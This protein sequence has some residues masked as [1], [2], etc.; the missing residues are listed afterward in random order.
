[1]SSDPNIFECLLDPSEIFDFYQKIGITLKN[2]RDIANER[3]RGH[4]LRNTLML[5]ERTEMIQ[6]RDDEYSKLTSC[7]TFDS[8]YATLISGIKN[9]YTDEVSTIINCDKHYDEVKNQF[10]IY[11]NDIPLR[12]MGLAMLME[13]TREFLRVKNRVYFIGIDNYLDVIKQ[14]PVVSLEELQEKL[15]R[16]AEH[17]EKAERFAYEFEKNRLKQ[18]GIDKEPL[19]ISSFDVMAGY[20]IVSYESS[21]SDCYD[22]FIEV[23]AVSKIGFYWSRNEYETA[24]LKADKYFLYLV[25]LKRVNEPRY[26][27]EV[28]RNPSQDVMESDEWY[29]EAQSYHIKR[30]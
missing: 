7:Q 28:I 15:L 16:D 20:D 29:V 24:K 11:V 1:M 21:L 25:D 2:E 12:Y 13:Q 23:K 18:L 3:I 10:F 19:R 8:F 5:L 6:R 14:K 9:I 17:G 22:R 26:A 27:P 4:A 30:I